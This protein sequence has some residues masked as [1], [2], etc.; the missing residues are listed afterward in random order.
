MRREVAQ[1]RRPRA[2]RTARRISKLAGPRPASGN[3]VADMEVVD[4]TKR[5]VPSA[6]NTVNWRKAQDA[7]Q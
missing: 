5:L 1:L 4:G 3:G 7:V 2:P 6:A